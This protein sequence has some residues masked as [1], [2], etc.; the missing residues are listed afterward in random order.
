MVRPMAEHGA[1]SAERPPRARALNNNCKSGARS[2]TGAAGV[3]LAEEWGLNCEINVRARH[4]CGTSLPHRFLRARRGFFAI[5]NRVT[6]YS[7]WQLNVARAARGVDASALKDRNTACASLRRKVRP[8]TMR[9]PPSSPSKAAAPKTSELP[10]AKSAPQLRDQDSPDNVQQTPPP[11]PPIQEL[12]PAV[13]T[14]RGPASPNGGE[15]GRTLDGVL[16]ALMGTADGHRRDCALR[17]ENGSRSATTSAT[18]R[19]APTRRLFGDGFTIRRRATSPYPNRRR[20]SGRGARRAHGARR[21]RGIPAPDDADH[22][23]RTTPLL[24]GRTRL[25]VPRSSARARRTWCGWKWRITCRRPMRT[26][27]PIWTPSGGPSAASRLSKPETLIGRAVVA[28]EALRQKMNTHHRGR[29]TAAV[30]PCASRKN[31]PPP[32]TMLYKHF[33]RRWRRRAGSV[34]A[35]TSRVPRHRALLLSFPSM[36]RR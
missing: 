21:R 14:R 23:T 19:T 17:L 8:E 7:L 13:R 32:V 30:V 11:V 4:Y 34:I 36:C 6:A 16:D 18:I 29:Q 31:Y 27:T 33:S 25:R 15:A 28:P 9:S 3:E 26:S 22:A 1:R 24:S 35:I 5:C 20:G 10:R 2:V 12:P